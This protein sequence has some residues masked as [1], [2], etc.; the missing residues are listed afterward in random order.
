MPTSCVSENHCGTNAPGWLNGTHPTVAKVWSLNKSAS[1]GFQ[2]AVILLST[3]KFETVDVTMST[4]SMEH[5]RPIHVILVFV[6]LIKKCLVEFHFRKC[7]RRLV[8]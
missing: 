7:F 5:H 4:S 1:P 8:N 6:A 3:F 2:T